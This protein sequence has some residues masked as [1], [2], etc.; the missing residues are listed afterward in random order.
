MDASDGA[1]G[2]KLI[3]VLGSLSYSIPS[4]PRGPLT[5]APIQTLTLPCQIRMLHIYTM[6]LQY[7]H[8]RQ[9]GF[10]SYSLTR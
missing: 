4:N 9:Q 1:N 8:H 5:T 7:H 3:A 2:N 10:H 6:F